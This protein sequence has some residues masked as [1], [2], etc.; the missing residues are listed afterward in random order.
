[1]PP[2]RRRT[3]V[4]V[5]GILRGSDPALRDEVVLIAAHYDH[6]GVRSPGVNGD[7]IYN[8]ADDDASGVT[9][10]LEIARQLAQGP[11]PKR[12]VIFAAMT[13]EEVGLIGTNWYLNLPVMPLEQTVANLAIEMILRPDSLVFGAGH[14]RL[15][16]FERSTMVEMFQAAGLMVFPDA[17][18]EQSFFTR[19]ETSGSPGAGSS[20]TRCRRSTCTP[21]TTVREM[22]GST[23]ISI[24]CS[25]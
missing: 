15:T 21:T 18:P 4:N 1:V 3:E 23:P 2:A 7:S 14:A 13:G 16:G 17:R 19:S 25:A 12:T 22:N 6:L 11:S 9:A 24:T 20:R 5:V 8:G 10:V